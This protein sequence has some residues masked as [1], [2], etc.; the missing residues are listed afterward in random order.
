[1]IGARAHARIGDVGEVLVEHGH[2]PRSGT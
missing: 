1:M 2:E